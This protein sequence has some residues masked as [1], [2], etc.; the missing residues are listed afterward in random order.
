M[1]TMPSHAT[2]PLTVSSRTVPAGRVAKQGRNTAPLRGFMEHQRRL[3][4]KLG[5]IGAGKVGCACARP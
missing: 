3:P 4:V 1:R 2:E 5:I